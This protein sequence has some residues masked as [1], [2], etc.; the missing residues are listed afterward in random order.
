LDAVLSYVQLVLGDVVKNERRHFY[1]SIVF[2]M[3]EGG[4]GYA[5]NAEDE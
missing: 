4:L 5:W 1:L 3:L 2:S